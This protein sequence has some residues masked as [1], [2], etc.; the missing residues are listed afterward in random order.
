MKKKINYISSDLLWKLLP[1]YCLLPEKRIMKV[2]G[3]LL[4]CLFVLKDLA[5]H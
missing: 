5:N 1:C 4:V 3:C 2:K